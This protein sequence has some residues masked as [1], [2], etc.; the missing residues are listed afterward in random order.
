LS[1]LWLGKRASVF[2]REQPDFLQI[3]HS[4]DS[5]EAE[6]RIPRIADIALLGVR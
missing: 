5:R 1:G 2:S 3:D 6:K 4:L